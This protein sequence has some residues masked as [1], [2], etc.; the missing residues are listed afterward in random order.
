MSYAKLTS[1]SQTYRA[2]RD[3]SGSRLYGLW[4]ALRLWAVR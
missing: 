1:W 2:Y 3:M 4:A